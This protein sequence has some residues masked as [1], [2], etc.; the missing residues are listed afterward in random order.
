MLSA[1]LILL[2]PLYDDIGHVVN[3]GLLCKINQ[4]NEAYIILQYCICMQQH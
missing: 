3:F 4:T 1:K 2:K